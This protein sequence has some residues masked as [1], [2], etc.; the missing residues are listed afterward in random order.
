MSQAG[1]EEAEQIMIFK[2]LERRTISFLRESRLGAIGQG[3]KIDRT[4]EVSVAVGPSGLGAVTK[5]TG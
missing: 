3:L 5:G 2:L 1:G 4:K